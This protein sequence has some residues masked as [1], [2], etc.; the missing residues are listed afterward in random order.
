MPNFIKKIQDQPRNVRLQ[1]FW[2]SVVLAVLLV[3]VFWVISL[4]HQITRIGKSEE[5]AKEKSFFQDLKASFKSG[6]DA[7]KKQNEELNKALYN[8]ENQ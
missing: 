3:G 7:F 4:K 2:A 5:L 8:Q 6:S 1:M